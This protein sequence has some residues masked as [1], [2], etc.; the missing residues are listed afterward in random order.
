MKNIAIPNKSYTKRVI[1]NGKT[2]G[3]IAIHKRV[4]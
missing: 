4:K 2:K 1:N 3:K